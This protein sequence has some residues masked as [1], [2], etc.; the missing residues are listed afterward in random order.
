MGLYNSLKMLFE[1]R[2][3]G[4]LY[5]PIG[6]EWLTEGY[7]RMAE[8]YNNHPAT[9]AQYLGIR[10]DFMIVGDYEY[11]VWEPQHQ[12]W[13]NA[14][15]LDGFFETKPDIVIASIPEHIEPF[16]RLAKLVGAKMVYQ[17]GNAWPVEAG[18]A[19][20]IMASANV[21]GVPDNINFIKYHQE[22][23]LDIFHQYLPVINKNIFSFV[24]CFNTASIYEKDWPVFTQIE[25][26]MSDWTFRGFG[27]SCRDGV[28][29]GQKEVAKMMSQSRF[30]WHVKNG[31]DGY[32]HI[33]YNSAAIG[34]PLIIKK[35]YYA[36][37]MGEELLVDGETCIT[38]DGLSYPEIVSKIEYHNQPVIYNKMVNNIWRNFKEKVSFDEEEK[39]IRKFIAKLV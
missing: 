38:I 22:F 30:I 18:L 24:N 39:E 21:N 23:S 33:L 35:E 36:G 25:S 3:G 28:A 10:T 20:N 12:F 16:K 5:R 17:I 4:K 13:Q 1:N 19:P 34:R 9:V 29:N 2:L 37:K 32:G 14:I 8:I 27:G 11:K 7:W 6:E 26:I 15:T 31:G